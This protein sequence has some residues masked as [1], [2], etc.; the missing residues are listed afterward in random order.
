MKN[1]KEE[2]KES[3]NTIKI[4]TLGETGVGKTSILKRY[5]YNSFEEDTISTIGLN[6]GIKEIILKDNTKIKLSL[7]DTA[8]QE[9]Y[10]SL[11]TTYFKNADAVLYV[12]SLDKKGSYEKIK[13]WKNMFKQMQKDEGVP[14][15][16]IRN[17]C[18]L[19]EL[20]INEVDKFNEEDINDF[21]E[22][23][24]FLKYITTSAKDNTNIDK[25]FQEISEIWYNNPSN[26]NSKNNIKILKNHKEDQK[27]QEKKMKKKKCVLCIGDL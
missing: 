23:N 20:N 1:I 11:S 27:K 9:R 13:E 26:K 8:G 3:L 22:R 17:K 21:L 7:I 6:F 4:I 5:V 19:D 24:N 10:R 14:S 18:D 16:L 12:F 15:F 25:V 2:K